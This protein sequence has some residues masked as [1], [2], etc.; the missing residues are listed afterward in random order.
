[1]IARCR[2][3]GYRAVESLRKD[4]LTHQHLTADEI[5]TR[6]RNRRRLLCPKCGHLMDLTAETQSTCL[7]V[8]RPQAG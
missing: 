8:H 4:P 2:G 6:L 5:A 3:C 1:M 7:R